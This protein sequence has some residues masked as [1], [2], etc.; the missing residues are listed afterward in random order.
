MAATGGA[1]PAA[2]T[3]GALPAAATGSAFPPAATTPWQEL[4]KEYSSDEQLRQSISAA[5]QSLLGRRDEHADTT[6]STLSTLDLSLNQ[7]RKLFGHL[8]NED[9]QTTEDPNSVE[10]P[11]AAMLE[12]L[13][14][15]INDVDEQT[16]AINAQPSAANVV[17]QPAAANDGAADAAAADAA[18]GHPAG[19]EAIQQTQ[20]ISVG[21]IGTGKSHKWKDKFHEQKCEVVAPLTTHVKVK[22]LE[23]G[24]KGY[25]HK[26]LYKDFTVSR[27]QQDPPL[28]APEGAP[29]SASAANVVGQPAA[30]DAAAERAAAAPQD[31]DMVDA[32]LAAF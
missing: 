5:E 17:G 32:F 1:L 11:A 21:D 28:P 14:R 23:G 9:Q 7:A 16:K 2:A 30:A 25:A 10:L 19:T 13:Q 15:F 26:Y 8:M 24:A 22:M 4:L 20:Q 31:D 3:G 6:T 18:A 27:R 29:E 12:A